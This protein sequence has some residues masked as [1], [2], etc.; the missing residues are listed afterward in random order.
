MEHS[1]EMIETYKIL[2]GKCE[3]KGTPR[4]PTRSW[5]DNIK[6]D[7]QKIGRDDVE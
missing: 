2:A 3:G 5:K 6:T 1:R 4:R 7:R